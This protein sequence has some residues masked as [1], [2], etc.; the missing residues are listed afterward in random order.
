MYRCRTRIRRNLADTR[1]ESTGGTRP[2]TPDDRLGLRE[3]N[4]HG[5]QVRDGISVGSHGPELYT[6][7]V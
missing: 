6:S 3:L 5:K 1:I 4:L 7:V 2:A